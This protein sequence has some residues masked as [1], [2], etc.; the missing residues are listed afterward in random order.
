MEINFESTEDILNKLRSIGRTEDLAFSPNNSKLAIASYALSKVLIFDINIT[1]SYPTPKISLDSACEINSPSIHLPH[2]IAWIN[3]NTIIVANRSSNATILEIPDTKGHTNPVKLIALQVLPPINESAL[4]ST[5]CIDVHS[6]GGGLHEVFICSNSGNFVSHYI[7]DES[8][9]FSVKA[10][11]FLL[12]KDICIPDGVTVSQDGKWLAISNHE[13]HQA[14]IYANIQSLN[15]N[16]QPSAILNGASYPH[17]ITFSHDQQFIFLADAG[18]PF[19]YVYHNNTNNWS[20]DY[21]PTAKIKIMDDE[22]FQLGH[23][24]LQEGGAKGI[25]ITRDSTV[26]AITCSNKPLAFFHVK[27]F[28]NPSDNQAI[29]QSTLNSTA[30]HSESKLIEALL[31]ATKNMKVTQDELNIFHKDQIN[32]LKNSRSWQLTSPLRKIKTFISGLYS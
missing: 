11:A 8:E 25:S 6:L 10:S 5:D 4:H 22:T 14:L 17:G 12:K 9:S 18:T 1:S 16:S 19:V 32:L 26:I 13:H 7:L 23:N 20:G 31:R 3:N 28:V 21:Y 15:C 24:N 2:G 27:D 29:K 30:E